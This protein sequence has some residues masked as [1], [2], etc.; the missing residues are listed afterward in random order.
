MIFSLSNRNVPHLGENGSHIL[1]ILIRALTSI[2]HIFLLVERNWKIKIDHE[3]TGGGFI[4]RYYV[5]STR[6]NGK[7]RSKE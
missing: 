5:S 6:L 3:P 1:R 7:W 2:E 4:I